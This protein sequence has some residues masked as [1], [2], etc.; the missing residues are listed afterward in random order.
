M[1]TAQI[2]S[3]A[4]SHNISLIAEDGLLKIDAPKAALT[5]DFLET[6]KQHKAELLEV[7]LKSQVSHDPYV[8]NQV[9]EAVQDLPIT[10][11]QFIALTT[12]EDRELILSGDLPLKVLKAYGKSFA[13][14]IQTGRITFHP[15]FH[16]GIPNTKQYKTISF[17]K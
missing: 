17:E 1:N 5:D 2:L 13:D 8:L 11:D 7:L 3:Y 4:Q 9:K 12:K 6:A 10:I 15:T 14:G 16:H